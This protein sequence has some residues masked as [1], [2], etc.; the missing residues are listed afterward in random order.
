[1]LYTSYF[2]IKKLWLSSTS[3]FY[4]LL[5]LSKVIKLCEV[6][7]L[8]L[9]LISLLYFTITCLFN[10]V[11]SFLAQLSCFSLSSPQSI[12]PVILFPLSLT[13][14]KL[15]LL[16]PTRSSLDSL[17]WHPRPFAKWPYAHFLLPD[18]STLP[19]CCSLCLKS[20][21]HLVNVQCV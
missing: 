21:H 1:M 9:F 8:N 17:W 3:L 19:L 10:F 16:F 2:S 20:C 5:D 12:S 18:S 11:L 15:V 7:L 13:F 6:S 4:W 14:L